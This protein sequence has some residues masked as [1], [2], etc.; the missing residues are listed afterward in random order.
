MQTVAPLISFGYL[1][2][3]ICRVVISLLFVFGAIRTGGSE[4]IVDI[5][6]KYYSINW[7]PIF[8]FIILLYIDMEAKQVKRRRAPNFS[9]YYNSILLTLVEKHKFKIENKNR[10]NVFKE[11]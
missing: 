7:R 9:A 4:C 11:K 1:A 8:A 3:V 6:S 2:V 10:W 5:F